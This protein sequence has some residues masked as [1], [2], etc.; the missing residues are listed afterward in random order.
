M[1]RLIVP[2]TSFY[3][4]SSTV[5]TLGAPAGV[6]G[7]SMGNPAPLQPA[8]LHQAAMMIHQHHQQQQQNQQQQNG[9]SQQLSQPGSSAASSASAIATTEKQQTVAAGIKVPGSV[10]EPSATTHHFPRQ[11][12]S[13]PSNG[14]DLAAAVSAAR[15]SQVAAAAAALQASNSAA[16]ATPHHPHHP[17][18]PHPHTPHPFGSIAQQNP[19]PGGIPTPGSL[20]P[21][22][23]GLPH[24]PPPHGPGLFGQPGHPGAAAAAALF[25]GHPA[26]AAAT[27]GIHP[28][29]AAAASSGHFSGYHAPD[30]FGPMDFNM[31]TRRKN[32]TRET[33]SAL[34]AWLSE[35]KKNPY[36]TKGE[37]IML[38][39]I[40]KMTL[41]Q[42]S[43]WFANARR[44]LKK[45]NKMTWAQGSNDDDDDDDEQD[46]AEDDD[47]DD[48]VIEGKV[49]DLNELMSREN[50]TNGA[51]QLHTAQKPS[52]LG[53]HFGG[54]E[55][56]EGLRIETNIPNP[57]KRSSSADL[58]T[59]ATSLSNV[60]SQSDPT[61][62]LP[63]SP[64]SRSE[65]ELNT[66]S[67][68]DSSSASWSF[69]DSKQTSRP[70]QINLSNNSKTNTAISSN[71][72]A[73]SSELPNSAK[74]S[75]IWSIADLATSPTVSN[76]SSTSRSTT[77]QISPASFPSPANQ[78]SPIWKS[79]KIGFENFGESY[80]QDSAN[81]LKVENYFGRSPSFF[82]GFSSNPGAM[83]AAI[84]AGFHP[85]F[86]SPVS[87]FNF[88]GQSVI[89]KNF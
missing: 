29:L 53:H 60:S 13:V 30:G 37:K 89:P 5:G 59:S 55:P 31:I 62:A 46:D 10:G 66:S 7:A 68:H 36:P 71:R 8:S 52:Q 32:A 25:A 26:T 45:E 85:T 27:G 41:T 20:T 47:V 81:I 84:S 1:N 42:V 21:G 4:P 88:N 38:A 2:P 64:T 56:T 34:K 33:T 28:L 12:T 17:A 74:K 50:F 6:V 48:D 22:H 16:A 73:G 11:I 87:M 70:L 86:S 58:F 49:N 72:S 19:G 76:E 67:H 24:P 80:N 61:Y 77:C 57:S 51:N 69:S 54:S 15:N 75:K 65:S 9:N 3:N 35:H 44:R 18:H 39:I 63:S 83:S 82:P 78:I 23:P 79:P 14:F 43:T 40:T